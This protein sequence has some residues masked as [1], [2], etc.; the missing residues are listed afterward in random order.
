MFIS[1]RLLIIISIVGIIALGALGF[2]IVLF[3]NQSNANATGSSAA[4]TPTAIATTTRSTATRVC[5]TGTIS[6]IDAQ[7]S[8]FVV[9]EAKGSRSVT[10]TAD[11]QTTFHKRG[12]TGVNFSSL[13][14]GQRVRVTSQ[15]ACDTTATTF[16]AKAITII[17][18]T[19]PASTPTTSPTP[20][21]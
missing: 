15:S 11:A 18:P 3:L 9:K 2:T 19:S 7:N 13:I 20:T 1:K 17:V 16:T 21:P 14:V 4:S 5:A 12:D 10:V 8:T 6:S